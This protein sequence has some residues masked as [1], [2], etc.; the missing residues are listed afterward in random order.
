MLVPLPVP[1]GRPPEDKAA[2]AVPPAGARE[3]CKRVAARPAEATPYSKAARE[4]PQEAPSRCNYSGGAGV[5]GGL[6]AG[7]AGG[8]KRYGPG[9]CHRVGMRSVRTGF[10][11]GCARRRVTG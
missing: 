9:R 1:E 3:A 6:G 7:G 2:A 4:K 8:G 11:T 5:A 10:F